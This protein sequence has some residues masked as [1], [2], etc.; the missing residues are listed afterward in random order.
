MSTAGINKTRLENHGTVAH[1][2]GKEKGLPRILFPL[3]FG[4]LLSVSSKTI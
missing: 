2:S 3:N 1:T 4:K